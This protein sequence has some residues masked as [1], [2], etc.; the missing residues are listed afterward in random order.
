[1][2]SLDQIVR[3]N[4]KNLKPYSSARDEFSGQ[5]GVFLD[6]NEN[7]FGELNRYPDPYQ[8]E[9]KRKLSELKKVSTEEIFIGNGS[10]ELI[11]LVFRIFCEPGKDQ[12]LTFAPTYGMYDVS[13]AINDVELIKVALTADFQI[14]FDLLKN[15]LNEHVKL[16]F[17]CSP[18]NPTG[19]NIDGIDQV[20]EMFNG[21][22]IVDEAY[23]DFSS[24]DS[25]INKIDQF[26]NLIV[27]QTFSKAWGLAG[28]RVG[29]AYS[30]KEIISL[31]NKVKPPYNVSELNQQVVLKALSNDELF[32]ERKEIILSQR[33]WLEAE[34]K[35]L[36]QV[37]KTYPS[38]ANFLLAE[39]EDANDTYQKLVDQKVIT[40]NRNGLVNNCIRITVG[41]VEEN[42]ALIEAFNKI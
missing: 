16:I 10:D 26:P 5:E 28:A 30:G 31:L 3:N 37:R 13:A 21:I 40:R 27:T 20:L 15:K 12:A 33:C 18:N 42:Q 17:L 41:S 38:D 2:F 25:M 11:D 4:I 1:M 29:A 6:A 34:L 23:I 39:V 19:N 32:K 35:G 8:R 24:S 36:K 7:P 9:V 22:V 14:D